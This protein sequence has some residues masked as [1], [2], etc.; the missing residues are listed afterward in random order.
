MTELH[1]IPDAQSAWRV[2]ETDSAEALSEHTSATD[3]ELAARARAE[4]RA[5]E[6]VVVH[7]RYHR[8]HDH[9]DS[10]SPGSASPAAAPR[11]CWRRRLAVPRW[12]VSTRAP[13][14]GEHR[15]HGLAPHATRAVLGRGPCSAADSE[16]SDHARTGCPAALD[17]RGMTVHQ[18]RLGDPRQSE[19]SQCLDI[20]GV[21][22]SD[23]PRGRPGKGR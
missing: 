19:E 4:D 14:S 11:E 5:V 23:R 2:Y 20:W 18:A 9:A 1:V 16:R 7:D 17:A 6:R 8:T 10:N 13:A 22:R 21:S 15:A 12:P 3:A